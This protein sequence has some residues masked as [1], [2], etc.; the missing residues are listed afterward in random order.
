MYK[1]KKNGKTIP[2]KTFESYEKARQFARKAIRKNHSEDRYKVTLFPGD[3]D[4]I[5]R[6]PPSIRDYGYEVVRV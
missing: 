3:W 4:N 5:S 6:N 1:L 2:K